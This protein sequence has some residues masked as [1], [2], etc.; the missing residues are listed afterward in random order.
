MYHIF[1]IT[2]IF[3]SPLGIKL[4]ISLVQDDYRPLRHG[5][6]CCYFVVP[7]GALWWEPN[8]TTWHRQFYLGTSNFCLFDCFLFLQTNI[9]NYNFS[10]RIGLKTEIIGFL[11]VLSLQY[12]ENNGF[13][14]SIKS[15][16]FYRSSF[17][18]IYNFQELCLSFCQ[19]LMLGNSINSKYL[20]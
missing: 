5:S 18:S 14:L 4:G 19:W 7:T 8:K 3:L 10:E 2:T 6:W 20:I 16:S 17:S 1:L 9:K 11:L 13:Y 12:D 15:L